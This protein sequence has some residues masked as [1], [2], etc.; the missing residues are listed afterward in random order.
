MQ[1]M[2]MNRVSELTI[3]TY[4]EVFGGTACTAASQGAPRQNN[5]PADPT[6]TAEHRVR[7]ARCTTLL[8][9]SLLLLLAALLECE[10][11]HALLSP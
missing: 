10:S 4:L 1:H 8:R 5:H 7:R 3:V 6:R 9:D 2:A 11:H